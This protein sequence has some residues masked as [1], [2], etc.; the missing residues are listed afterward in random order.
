ME[1]VGSTKLF[2]GGKHE[3]N[4]EYQCPDG[5]K[6]MTLRCPGSYAWCQAS[7]NPEN[8]DFVPVP[9]DAPT[10]NP[11]PGFDNDGNGPICTM[12][13]KGCPDGS[14]VG[15]TGP[16]C[17][18]AECPKSQPD[19][20]P[21]NPAK[22]KLCTKEYKPVCGEVDTRIRCI[23]APCPSTK[24][25]TFSN[26]C[27]A[28]SAGAKILYEGRCKNENSAKNVE[29]PK[30]CKTWFDGCN[31]CGVENGE[32]AMC[33]LMF[34]EKLAEPKC[35]EFKNNNFERNIKCLDKKNAIKK[36]IKTW[37]N[38]LSIESIFYSQKE[39]EC[40]V[41][42]DTQFEFPYSKKQLF[43]LSQLSKSSRAIEGCMEEGYST[44]NKFVQDI[45]EK[46]K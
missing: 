6:R 19:I 45:T 29:I 43:K 33:T 8:E 34:C 41:L 9:Q 44:C 18:F 3:E 30:N 16:N 23:K 31:N 17:E 14:F 28:K 5:L 4:G 27:M 25:K 37:H 21:E 22:N 26:K 7:S 32:L 38:E 11:G 20:I 13:A 10:I 24:Q 42:L 2:P 36:E 35:V 15:R 1:V 40:L 12:D 46:Y 39:N